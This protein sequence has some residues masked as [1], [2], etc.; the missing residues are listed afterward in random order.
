MENIIETF[1]KEEQA[2]FIMAL[3]LL[4]FALVMSYA[5]VQDY[6][7]YLD[8]N[9]KARYSFCDFIKRERFYIFFCLHPFLSAWQISCIFWSELNNKQTNLNN[10]YNI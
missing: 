8:E 5:M 1:M 9:Y 4:I 10:K 3:F 6:R 2:I 7:M